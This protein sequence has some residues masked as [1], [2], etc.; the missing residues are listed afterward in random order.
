MWYADIVDEKPVYRYSNHPTFMYWAFSQLSRQ[1]TLGDINLS[2][3]KYDLTV[4][5]TKERIEEMIRNN[6]KTIERFIHQSTK[7]VP[8]S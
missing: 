1:D 6:E 2:L 4:H 3:K 8:G 7:K 5:F